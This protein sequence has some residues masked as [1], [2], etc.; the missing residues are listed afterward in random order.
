[1]DIVDVASTKTDSA[2]TVYDVKWAFNVVSNYNFSANDACM[3]VVDIHVW[4]F[5]NGASKHITSYHNLF[6][7]LEI[8]SP[9]NIVM[10]ANNL[11]YSI[12]GI[13]KF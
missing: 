7:F 2:N 13:G 5:D 9:R 8:V 11:S 3:T 4:Y 6:S 12:K 1:M 10:C